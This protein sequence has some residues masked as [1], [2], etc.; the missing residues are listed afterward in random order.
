MDVHLRFTENA[1]RGCSLFSVGALP[2]IWVCCLILVSGAANRVRAEETKRVLIVHSFGSAAPPFTTHSAAFETELTERLGEKLDLDEVSLDHARYTDPDM[3]NAL[4]EY[5]QKRQA[6]WQPDLVVPIGSPAGIF[7]EKYR[8]RLF[9]QAAIL[10]TGMDRRRLGADALK[11]N[12]AFVGE[13]FDG[14]GFVDDI[15]HLAPDTTNIVCIIGASPVERY[16]TAAFQ[17]E[18]ARFTNRVS[19]T[20]LNDLSFDQML[21]RVKKLPPHS[22]VFFILLIRDAAGVTHNA[23]EA[24]SLLCKVANAPVNSIYEHQLGLGIVGGRLYRAEFEGA[25]SARLAVRILHGEAASNIPPEFVGPVGSQYDWRELRTWGISEGRLPPGSIVKYRQATFWERYGYLIVVGVSVVFVQSVLIAGLV[26]NLNRRRK[27]ERSL[28]ESEQRFRTIADSAPVLIWMAGT[29][30]KCLF[31]NRSW[32]EFTGRKMEQEPANGWAESIHP[33]HLEH[34]LR[35][36]NTAFDARMPF[37]MEY[38]LRRHDG[39]YRWVMD[40]GVPRYGPNQDFL[41]YVDVAID[42]T[43]RKS[44]EEARQRLVHISRLSAVGELTAMIVHELNQPLSAMRFNIEAAKA[45]VDPQSAASRQL[46]EVLADIHADNR[47]AAEA[48]QRIRALVSKRELQIQAVNMNECVS[49]VVR[50]VESELMHRSV[51]LHADCHAPD[52]TVRGDTVH[53]Q[54]VI[55]NLIINAMDAMKDCLESERHLFISTAAN[56]DGYVEVSISDTGRGIETENLSRIFES[57]FTTKPD[58][59]GMGLYLARLVVQSH[60]GRLW[61]ENNKNGQGTTL[62]FILPVVL[63][64]APKPSPLKEASACTAAT[65]Q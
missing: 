61:A 38:R 5:L 23:D 32:L 42:L 18:F 49:E 16:W 63:T 29:D 28:R 64:E 27:A 15:L 62:R 53:L 6:K 33:E 13:S 8:D 21:E 54:H 4:V 50:L 7:V 17:S 57:F 45:L 20:W 12:A 39:E 46:L 31:F 26:V 47:R 35:I 40:R 30:K 65:G 22:F 41:G 10:Y 3:E 56:V 58:G 11:N 25:E 51:Q 9:P 19:F 52:A 34:S 44:A 36:Y 14:P 1:K 37:E 60:S 55:L 43:D 24:L 59:M 48:I 2:V